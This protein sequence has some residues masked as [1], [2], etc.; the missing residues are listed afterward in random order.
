MGQPSPAEIDRYDI[1][2]LARLRATFVSTDLITPADPSTVLFF[3]KNA[4][5]SVSTYQ[6]AQAGAS[7]TRAATGAY[8][9]D[10]TVDQTG[11]WFYR[12]QGTGGVQAADEWGLIVDRSFIL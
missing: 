9:K 8:Y 6:Y 4:Q 12:A 2:D 7:V 5:G 11:T 1:Y 10:I 3:V